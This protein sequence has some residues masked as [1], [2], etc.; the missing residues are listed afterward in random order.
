M[1]TSSEPW[2]VTVIR[3]LVNPATV[4]ALAIVFTFRKQIAE[5]I[6]QLKGF[7]A[8]GVSA[9]MA[10][11]QDSVTST[12][13]ELSGAITEVPTLEATA[14]DGGGAKTHEI[15]FPGV[16]R[17]DKALE[18]T[19]KL[20]PPNAVDDNALQRAARYWA[21]AW[22][23]EHNYRLIFGTQLSV[24]RAANTA[25]VPKSFVEQQY[26]ASVALG[27]KQQ[28]FDQYVGFLISS[29]FL[30]PAEDGQTY[31]IRLAGRMLLLYI[32][33]QGYPDKQAF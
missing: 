3:L 25:P 28:T 21:I 14:A 13:G 29:L 24:L 15:L 6:P 27:N 7:S 19:K 16:M 26:R 11:A 9:D 4:L 32:P 20:L 5:R 17:T 18:E 2:W 12:G 31:S 10:T 23:L 1:V 8:A 30:K 22:N 33:M